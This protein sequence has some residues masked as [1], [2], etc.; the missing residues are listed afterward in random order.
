MPLTCPPPQRRSRL[1]RFLAFDNYSVI[2]QSVRAQWPGAR[3]IAN[4]AAFRASLALDT[5]SAKY[6]SRRRCLRF[7]GGVTALNGNVRYIP[8][9]EK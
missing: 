2:Y 7:G 1:R 4:G 5:V 8:H 3:A 6:S 9:G